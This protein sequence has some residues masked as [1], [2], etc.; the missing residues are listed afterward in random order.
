[1]PALPFAAVL[2]TYGAYRLVRRAPWVTRR[3]RELDAIVLIAIA[4]WIVVAVVLVYP[5]SLAI[6]ERFLL[7]APLGI[8]AALVVALVLAARGRRGAAEAALALVLAGV[9]WAGMTELSYDAFAIFRARA[10]NRRTAQM[11]AAQT[12]P[13]A[14]V[15]AMYPDLVSDTM[16]IGDVIA[17]PARDGFAS[18]SAIVA[19]A[20]RSGRPSYAVLDDAS[21]ARLR[22]AASH[23]GL[24]VSEPLARERTLTL[25][26]LE[27]TP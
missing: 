22:R 25:R 1:M 21:I 9:V 11:V 16:E 23:S 6:H 19:E 5:S 10:S 7:D 20:A 27:V 26:R 17:E 18:V 24:R 4:A 3:L 15:F 14:V 13:G 12:P 8:A 2:A